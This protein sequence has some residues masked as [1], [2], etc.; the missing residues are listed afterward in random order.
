VSK[1]AHRITALSAKQRELLELR[2]KR[3]GIDASALPILPRSDEGNRFPL[4]FAQERLWF[5]D[6]LAPGGSPYVIAGA[7][8]LSGQLNVGALELSLNEVVRRHQAL[9]TRFV[10]VEGQPT[11][12]IDPTA[13]VTVP[14][15][16]LNE[17]PESER[18]AHLLSLITE[19]AQ[20][21]FDLGR[22]PLLRTQL[23]RL[24]RQ[25]HMLLLT[26][27]HIVSDGWSMEILIRELATLYQAFCDGKPSP[28]VELPIQFADVAAWQ[29]QWL[30]GE[31]LQS[32]LSYWKQH[33]Q[34]APAVL[35][36]PTD[37]P[38]P[39]VQSFRGARQSLVLSKSLI[40]ELKSLSQPEG[41]TLFMTLLAAFQTL[42]YRYTGQ[43]DIVVGSPT[44]NRHRVE[45]E[46]LIGFFA[47]TLVFRADLSGNP[48]FR[49]L[50]SRMREMMLQAYA[51][52]DLPFERLVEEL[53]PERALSHTPL[54]QVMLAWQPAPL[55]AVELPGLRLSPVEVDTGAAKFDLTV[56]MVEQADGSVTGTW[57]YNRELFEA[58]TIRRMAGHF[59]TLLEALV[60]D[61]DQRVSELPLLRPVERQQL[62]LEWNA[63]QAEFPNHVCL[64]ELFQAQVERTPDAV[65]V[66]CQ[67]EQVS[68]E[69]LNRRANQVAHYLR[70]WGVGPEALVGI[71]LERTVEM[72]VAMLGIL[73]AGGA[74]VP[75]DPDYPAER[76]GFI[77]E[78]TQAPVVLTQRGLMERVPNC[79]ARVLDLDEEWE[80]ISRQSEENPIGGATADSVAYVIY[81]SGS[82]GRPKGV[83]IEHHS[84]VAL[85]HWAQELWSP[86]PLAKVLASTSICF[87]LSVF[88]LFVPLSWGGTV[89]LA[90]NALQLP[91]LPAGQE[92]MLI[93]TVPSAIAELVRGEAVPA[94]VRIVNLAG[95]PLSGKLVQ[96]LY[97]QETIEQVFNLYGPSEYTTYT[98]CELMKRSAGKTPSIGR[99]I[100][101]TQVYVLGKRLE[102]L[103]V[104]VAG[105]LYI[106]GEGLARGYLRRPELTA[107]RFIPNPFHRWPSADG[108]WRI[109]DSEISKAE[110][111]MGSESGGRLY[112]TGDLVRYRP[113]GELE[114]LGR[115]DH[116]VKIRGFR[117]ELGEIEAVL[118]QHPAVQEV[119]VLALEDRPGDKQLVAHVVWKPGARATIS[120]LRGY[121]NQRLPQYMMPSGFVEIEKMPLLPNGKVDRQALARL[122]SAG[123]ELEREY[124]APCTPTEGI[125][126]GIW[127]EVLRRERVGVHDN[128]FELGGHSLLATRLISRLR[129]IFQIE[130][131]L[132]TLFEGPTVAH[133]AQSIEAARPVA[134]RWPV[135]PLQPVPRDETLPLSF[136]Q[137]R[138]WFLDQLDPG[139]PVYNIAAAVRIRGRLNVWAL[140]QSLNEI[141]RR[142][143]V[144]R[145]SFATVDGRPVQVIAPA[146]MLALSV[147]D[148]RDR[149]E[150]EREAEVRRLAAEEAQRPFD[151]TQGPLLR[152]SMLQVAE[153]EQVL[154]LLL[155]HIISD[156][157][158]MGVL[159]EELAAL[160][161]AFGDGGPSPLP[162]LPIQYP[163]FAAW[164]QQ[165][166]QGEV[167]E[168]QLSY[169]KRHL[170]GVP[171]LEL[172]TDRPRPVVQ[173]AR[174]ARQWLELSKD[175]TSGLK[176]LS[177]REGVTLFMTLL[178]AF[179]TLLYRYT[180]QEDIV[181]GSL[182]ANR[183]W[184]ETE[185]LIGFFV[186]TL[187]LRTDLSGNPSF[188]ELLSRVREVA[189]EAYAHQ[190]APFERL[191]EELLPNRDLH[192]TP[193]FQVMFALQ[194]APMQ[195]L[196]LPE[197][198]LSP[199]DVDSRTAKFDLTLLMM[200]EADGRLTGSLEYNTDLFEEPTIMR[201]IGHF[202]TLLQGI[203]A[204]P[205]CCL[206]DLPVL[207]EPERRQLLLEWNS[208]QLDYPQ[209]ACV[210]E[211]FEAQVERTPAATAVVFE[212]A[213]LSYREL[214][215]RAN[216]L[217][218][219]LRALGVGPEVRVGICLERSLEL[220][221]GVLGILKAGGAYVPLDPEYPT[222]RLAFMLQDA[223]VPV[224]LSQSSL[225]DRC[226]GFDGPSHLSNRESQMTDCRTEP[227]PS[228]PLPLVHS[229]NPQIVCLDADWP[230]VAQHSTETVAG[231]VRPQNLI[232]VIYTSGSTGQPKGVMITHRGIV[233]HM[234]WMQR[235]LRHKPADRVMHRT[236][237]SFDGSV[238][239]LWWPLLV[240][241]R[242]ILARPGGH[243]DSAY[244]VKLIQEQHVTA[245][246]FVP[247]L[248]RVFVEETGVEQ[249]QSLEQVISGGEALP[250]DLVERLCARLEAQL[251]NLYG[252][253]EASI[254]TT[255]WSCERDRQER[256]IPIGRPINNV[257]V[258][259]LDKHQQPVPVGVA[260]QLHVTGTGLGR[261]YLNR[262]ELTAEK[263]IPNPFSQEPGA[264]MYKTG[265]L[266]RYRP[267]RN[268]EFLGRLDHQVKV[269]GFRIEL[270]EI[271]AVL[272]QHAAVQE[273]V[274][275]ARQDTP[276]DPRLVAYVVPKPEA[277]PA[278]H[279]LRRSL[280]QRLPDYMVPSAFV[281]LEAMPLTP[282][283]K[284]DR[285]ALPAPQRPERQPGFVAART[286]TEEILASLWSEV[287]G[288]GPVGVQDNFFE[289][290]GHS[291]LATKLMSRL[292][293]TFQLDLPLR[294]LFEEPTIA[295]LSETIEKARNSSAQL[296]SSTI[297]PVPR[298]LFR[299]KLR[300][301]QVM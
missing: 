249:C 50:L 79:G 279:D 34:G 241:G 195:A 185:K 59:Q 142:H 199:L 237:L 201:M 147:V 46:G 286:P 164:Q 154:L 253:T 77:V 116:Q 2:L 26:M 62:L 163:D 49:Q 179:K 65:A 132:R 204:H 15:V 48:R 210:H 194:N 149:L 25:E 293:Q 265:D 231:N 288:L 263:F 191:V 289:L 51:H 256:V 184:A 205:E 172:P 99:P 35:E 271:E 298:E 283:G 102:P 5:L 76:L 232:Y 238:W 83:A 188:Q 17:R 156:G 47:N 202:Q 118:G 292:R 27:H 168:T 151:L 16:D 291:L 221:V 33:L 190:D 300:S 290:G 54:F 251:H 131:P 236:P 247:S 91:S 266:V 227:D 3:Q 135:P 86:E 143:E 150:S 94:S 203:V 9:R 127:E 269:R 234:A 281:M 56:L 233:S 72:V 158:S 180:A 11:Q 13:T 261:G 224:L 125:L 215:R 282:S 167:L 36:L 287:L 37:Y 29:R 109:E 242:L 42:L 112:K 20:R 153:E 254:D 87:D 165:W 53:Q 43:E 285:R 239:E 38:R 58:E 73:K 126:A 189:L 160:Y 272:G 144:L 41:V 31:V 45:T 80:I 124:V 175:L 60:V 270:G 64:H 40:D 264:R 212:D 173:P 81:T 250:A 145:T 146:L 301:Q 100:S 192:H 225:L 181:V 187:V 223:Q 299:A 66:V 115:L 78:D 113:D 21:P 166:L 24:E 244:L 30:Q 243:K 96:Q 69:E 226:R 235:A 218:H 209:Q 107:E 129:K 4:S 170:A 177:R 105:E 278:I 12:V 19:E 240:G 114:F 1:F 22:G 259:L 262:P 162:P 217:A 74:Y 14:V 119:I 273:V 90:Q 268:I 186:N 138:L 274:V 93:N 123:L 245:V 84:A 207:T 133:L 108:R 57:E 294:A 120:E 193:L 260:G 122:D 8:R 183:P 222:E 208:T 152:V 95:E 117:I 103:P 106:G 88:E 296:E 52:Q 258:Y 246:E 169:W 55:Q 89:I 140:E 295:E 255:S 67:Q 111:G 196:E 248:L 178:A 137:Q 139:N 284:V 28:L 280:K 44:A 97:E 206:S 200:E 121:L 85:V 141:V 229:V 32:H 211:L 110:S 148:L 130:L 197:L 220:M 276:G 98:T 176:A 134:P 230:A 7:V 128:F 267:D 198:M 70:R 71:C 174:G 136:A 39:A 92:V 219:Y 171:V 228:A 182:I 155:H 82:T 275:L 214:N 68:Y 61:P 6:Q 18:E 297:L 159:I 277:A 104:G 75:L 216:Q 63:T 213:A 101:N 157:W 161:R 23:L 10:I 252:P 257:Q